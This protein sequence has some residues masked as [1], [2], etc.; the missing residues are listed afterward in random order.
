ML[1]LFIVIGF[2]FL[3]VFFHEIGHAIAAK[4]VGLS[5]SQYGFKLKPYPHFYI[6]IVW[7]KTKVQKYT[8]LFSGFTMSCILF[9]LSWS[10]SF[11]NC[12]YLIIAFIIHLTIETNPF[13]SDFTT[14]ILDAYARKEKI[15]IHNKDYKKHLSNY[16]FSSI[17][18]IHFLI[19]T[20]FVITLIKIKPLL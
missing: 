5:I 20:I 10:F 18:Y 8:Y 11:W 3:L 12:Q 17:W 13:F 14:A 2:V 16:Q 6:S 1:T 15:G 9:L 7:P 19:W 4:I